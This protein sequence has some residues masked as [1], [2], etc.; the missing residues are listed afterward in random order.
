MEI[1]KKSYEN[2]NFCMKCGNKLELFNDR[3][4]K[5]RP[6]CN[7]CGWIFYKNP[8]PAAAMVIMN[9][10][11]EIVIIKRLFEPKANEWALP[12]G[13]IDINQDPEEAACAEMHEETGLIG[14]VKEF[15]GYYSD[16]SSVV[17]KVISLGFLMKIKGGRLQAGDDATEARYVRVEDMPPI[18]FASH[19]HFIEKVTGIRCQGSVEK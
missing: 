9:E 11:Q 15:L 18:A 16:Y 1:T 7:N 3:E 4:G 17:E 13:Y 14:E 5:L 2:I 8:V 6:H 12:S 19:K 10:K